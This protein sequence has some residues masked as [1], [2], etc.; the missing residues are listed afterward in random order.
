MTNVGNRH[1][2]KDLFARNV[3]S[4]SVAESDQLH[5]HSMNGTNWPV[6]ESFGARSL[7]QPSEPE[8]LSGE[9]TSPTSRL[10]SED[11]GRAASAVAHST[12]GPSWGY[13]R[14]ALPRSWSHF[15]GNFHR[16]LTNLLKIDFEMPPRRALRGID[17]CLWSMEDAIGG[18]V[19]FGGVVNFAVELSAGAVF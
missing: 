10:S 5:F 14:P 9:R 12:E 8:Q 13:P 15:V 17:G 7:P 11:S 3:S 19:N 6:S 2:E 4:F 1:S 16:K 18:A